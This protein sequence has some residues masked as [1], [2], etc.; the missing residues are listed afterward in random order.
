MLK[1]NQTSDPDSG[2]Q[3]RW[4]IEM[5]WRFW[6]CIPFT[7]ASVISAEHKLPFLA[8]AFIAAA[9]MLAEKS[10]RYIERNLRHD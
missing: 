4:R 1:P 8:G 3:A 5:S 6:A 7:V 2:A 10:G 9:L